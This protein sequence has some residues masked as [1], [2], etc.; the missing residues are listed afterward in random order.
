MSSK[1]VLITGCSTGIGHDLARRLTLAKYTVIATARHPETLTDLPVALKLPLDVTDPTSVASATAEVIGC[2]GR[3]DILV[4]NAGYALL[5]AVEDISDEEVHKMFDVN[6]YGVMRMIRAVI[7][8]MRQQKAGRVINISSI[9]WKLV[10]PVGGTYSATK[11]AL[12]AL[13][14]ALRMELAPFGIQVVLI[15]PG[16]IQTN[17][18][19]T[20]QAHAKE[21][22]S[23]PDSPYQALYQQ[24]MQLTTTMRKSEPGPEI[25]SHV[26]QQAM[27]A[28]KPKAR[29]V[30]AVP[31]SLRFLLHLGD[32]V[33]DVIL[34]R[35]FKMV[36]SSK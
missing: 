10:T 11:F 27:E 33:R 32:S 24:F 3:I 8:Q 4:N 35:A 21:I 18:N 17:F 2:F 36:P 6:V 28:S 16:N 34:Q 30:V 26:V 23:H 20:A 31:F 29:Y 9:S 7:P 1:T 5:G 25:V 12:E 22:L 19:A 13:S 14:D 15:E